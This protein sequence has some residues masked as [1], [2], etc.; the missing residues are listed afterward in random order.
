MSLRVDANIVGS[1]LNR[2]VASVRSGAV[3]TVRFGREKPGGGAASAAPRYSDRKHQQWMLWSYAV[4]PEL[5]IGGSTPHRASHHAC[6]PKKEWRYLNGHS[7]ILA[8]IGRCPRSSR[9]TCS[10]C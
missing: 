3:R 4:Y 5:C 9:A 10:R 6:P 1:V 7:T 8:G 2:T